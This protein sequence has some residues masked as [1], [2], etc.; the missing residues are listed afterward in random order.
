[1]SLIK[2]IIYTHP[3]SKCNKVSKYEFKGFWCKQIHC[4]NQLLHCYNLKNS[5]KRGQDQNA[6]AAYEK[7]TSCYT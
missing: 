4:L 5:L 7:E 1:M 6:N 3:Y 2:S